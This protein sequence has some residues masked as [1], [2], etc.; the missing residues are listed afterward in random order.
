MKTMQMRQSPE[1]LEIWWQEYRKARS[2]TA[3]NKLMESYLYIVKYA[4]ERLHT[5]LPEEVDVDDL[6]SAGIFGL[7]DAVAAFDPTRGV[8][9]ETYCAPRIRGAILDAVRSLDTVGRAGREAA[10]AIQGA[11]RDLQHE[12]GRSPT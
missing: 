7:M 10:R 9:F 2:E 8:K 1:Q 11:I 4:A 12:L 3:R 5:K 6:I